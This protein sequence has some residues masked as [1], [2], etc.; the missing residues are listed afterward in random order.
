MTRVLTKLFAVWI[1]L[2]FSCSH[3]FAA[4]NGSVSGTVRDPSAAVIAGAKVTLSNTALR[5]EYTALTNGQG[6]YSF[7][8]LPVGESCVFSP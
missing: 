8:A 2:V 3:V 1:T 5:A 4:A 7:P 6:F